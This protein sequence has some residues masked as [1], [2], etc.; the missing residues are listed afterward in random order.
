MQIKLRFLGAAQNVTG[1]RHMLEVNGTRLLIDCGLYQERQ[2]KGRN[3]EPF[4]FPA[5]SIDAVLLTHAHLDHCGLL[6]KLVKEGFTGPV[7][8]TAATAEIAR[9]IMLDSARLQEEDAE[10]KRKRHEREGRKGPH[11]VVPLY[12]TADAEAT[13]PLFRKV[14][15]KTPVQIADGITAT[16]CEAGHVFGS[17]IIHVCIEKNGESR[18]VLFSGDVGRPDRPIVRDPAEVDEA[19]YILV[20]STYGDRVHR[21]HGDIKAEI[22]EV[23]NATKAA[24]GNII[25]PS[26]ALERSQDMLYYINELLAED[27]IPHLMVFLDSPMAGAITKVFKRHRELFDEE[28]TEFVKNGQSPFNFQGL[29]ITQTASESKAINHIRGTAIVIAGSGM[30]TGGRVKHHLVNNIERPESTIMFVGYQAIGTLGR[31][32]VNGEEEVRILGETRPVKARIVQIHGMSAHA[33]KEELLRWLSALKNHPKKIFVVHGEA[34]SAKSFGRYL[35]EK[36]GWEVMV[37][38]YKDEVVLD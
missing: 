23:I 4:D 17:A 13:E 14:R 27:A 9:I 28:M 5:S 31:R 32:I 33:D 35:Q 34:E 21:Q 25:V 12:T 26:F 3:W 18:S 11:P 38:E 6:P 22:A 19:D 16:F 1:S 2:F 7:Y 10:F 30:C 20:E 24:G 36:T 8:C 29:H 15:Y 37:P